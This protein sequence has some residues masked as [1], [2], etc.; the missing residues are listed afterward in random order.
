MGDLDLI[1]GLRRSPGKGKGYPL[2]YCG[3]ENSMDCMVQ[4]VAKRQ[5]QMSS[6]HFTY[7]GSTRKLICTVLALKIS[8]FLP[9]IKTKFLASFSLFPVS[10]AISYCW[11]HLG[12]YFHFVIIWCCLHIFTNHPSMVI[13]QFTISVLIIT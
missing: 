4:R 12:F 2:Q 9:Q 7:Y 3:L 13:L 1:P 5:T 6:F 11:S 10:K 8:Q